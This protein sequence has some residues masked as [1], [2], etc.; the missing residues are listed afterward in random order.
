MTLEEA[1]RD[2]GEDWLIDLYGPSDQAI[3]FLRERI[4]KINDVAQQRF[5]KN[6]PDLSEAGI[7]A[8]YSHN[9]LKVKGF[10]QN[11]GGTRTARTPE[12]LLMAWRIIQGAQIDEVNITYRRQKQFHMRVT[13]RPPDSEGE[14]VYESSA[15]QDFAI[16]RHIGLMEVSRGPVF[17]GFYALNL[18]IK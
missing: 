4:A 1:I 2:A 16:F 17:D 11:L 3:P 5:G 15:I 8:T 10:L 18:P 14:E 6:A 9:P 12:M 13:L 7:I